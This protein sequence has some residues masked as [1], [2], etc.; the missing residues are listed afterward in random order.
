M[1]DHRKALRRRNTE[2]QQEIWEEKRI[3]QAAP[4]EDRRRKV[5]TEGLDIEA[6][7]MEDHTRDS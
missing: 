1:E 2:G 3:F 7:V 6:L 4:Q 5:G